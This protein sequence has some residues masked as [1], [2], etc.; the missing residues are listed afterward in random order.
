MRR[1]AQALAVVVVAAGAVLAV[2]GAGRAEDKPLILKAQAVS[3][4][5]RLC[6]DEK[7]LGRYRDWRVRLIE[8][9]GTFESQTD[10]KPP[11]NCVSGYYRIIPFEPL[12]EYAFPDWNFHLERAGRYDCTKQ[13]P[14]A[15]AGNPACVPVLERGLWFR[16]L[17]LHDE[18]PL[19]VVAQ[20]FE[21]NLVPPATK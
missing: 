1:A 12:S 16:A 8:K 7:E 6:V 2:A 14:P 9:S 21:T 10:A 3:G 17:W 15:F 19:P 4:F 13:L 18:K 20:V 11:A 5:F